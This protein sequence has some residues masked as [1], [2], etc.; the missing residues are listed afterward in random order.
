[1]EP[2]KLILFVQIIVQ[3]LLLILVVVLII[4]EKKMS[5][6]AN[7]ID[8]L[9]KAIG[10]TQQLSDNF[11]HQINERMELVKRVMSDLESKLME[12]AQI[13]SALEE[14]T[15]QVKAIKKFTREDVLKLHNS[16]FEPER[17]SKITGIPTGEIELM[18][19]IKR[20]D[21]LET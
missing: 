18:V 19:K 7:S 9:K 21:N 12:A 1:L 3:I 2:T 20:P 5:V 10:E 6:S 15:Q 13:K 4:R 16:G 14:L 17:I 11:S 8:D